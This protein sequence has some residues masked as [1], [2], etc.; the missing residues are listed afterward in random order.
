MTMNQNKTE[1]TPVRQQL[2]E[3]ALSVIQH[4]GLSQLSADRIA[5]QLGR[6]QAEVEAHFPSLNSLYKGIQNYF[7]ATLEKNYKY[8]AESCYYEGEHLKAVLFGLVRCCLASLRQAQ[9]D[10]LLAAYS[11]VRSQSPIKAAP[12]MQEA[13]DT[14]ERSFKAINPSYQQAGELADRLVG[15]AISFTID[16]THLPKLWN[17][18]RLVDGLAHQVSDLLEYTAF[19]L[20]YKREQIAA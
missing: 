5:Q 1:M 12:Y 16:A 14:I 20:I 15:M 6:P 3:A 10:N 4:E 2:I 19:G 17:E 7:W 18:T 11:I 13:R 9:M 8:D